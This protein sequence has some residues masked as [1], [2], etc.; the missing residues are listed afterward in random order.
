MVQKYFSLT[1]FTLLFSFT[2]TAAG[3]GFA[4]VVDQPTYIALPAITV[5]I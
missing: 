4:I 5:L 2:V 1:V 3:K